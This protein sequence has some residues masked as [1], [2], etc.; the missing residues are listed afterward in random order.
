VLGH[1]FA[2]AIEFDQDWN[3]GPRQA[4]SHGHNSLLCKSLGRYDSRSGPSFDS[5]VNCTTASLTVRTASG[6][7]GK[8]GVPD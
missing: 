3:N 6:D 1:S 7:P 8:Y 5:R 2:A 4:T